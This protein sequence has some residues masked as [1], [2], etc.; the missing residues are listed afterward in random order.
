MMYATVSSS[1]KSG[2]FNPISD[3]SPLV[4]P[5]FGGSPDNAFFDP[6]F[7]DSFEVGVK[8]TLLDGAMRINAAGFF[9]DYK[10]LQQSK[11]CLLYTSPSPRDQRGSRMPSSA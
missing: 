7:I 1:F 9:Y 4:D 10:D 6:E 3:N 2:G 5:A 11:I 8:T